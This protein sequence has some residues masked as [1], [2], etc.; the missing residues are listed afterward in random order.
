MAV[1]HSYGKMVTD[2]LVLY[3][4]AAD[5][6]SYV[7]GS[8][9]WYDLAGSNNG[10]LV[11]GPTYN[12]GSLGSI[13]F[14]GVNDYTSLGNVFNY[15]SE[16]FS[17]GYW[18]NFNSFT[19]NIPGQGPIIFYKGSYNTNGYYLQHGIT[20]FSFVTNQSGFSQT[21]TAIGV[22]TL[23]VWYYIVVTRDGTSVRGY[24]NGIDR[25]ITLGSHT[26][27]ASSTNNFTL[28]TYATFIYFNGK[29]SNFT[30]YNRVLSATEVLQN[31]NAT[32]TR[33]GLT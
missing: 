11:N 30:G 18:V 28:A 8:T 9:T 15:T 31:Y 24:V 14:D 26:N 29:I 10:T 20:G 17:F 5:A 16:S 12:S 27:P 22:N 32:K 19:T 6:N 7:S 21:T 2:G 1:Q 33:F 3:L 25:T 4:N 23:G 13:V